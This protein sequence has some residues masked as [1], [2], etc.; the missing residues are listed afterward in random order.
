MFDANLIF[1][2]GATNLTASGSQVLDFNGPDG[3]AIVYDVLVPTTPTGTLP[4]LDIKIEISEDNITWNPFLAMPQITAEGRYRVT[5]RTPK[6]YRKM[7]W[8]LGGTSPNFGK[9]TAGP[10][11][12]G[13]SI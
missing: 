5:G 6:R 13:V 9:V 1:L 11:V 2:S 7:T 4:T 10:T 8:T 12:G 3:M